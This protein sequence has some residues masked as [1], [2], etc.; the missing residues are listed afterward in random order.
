MQTLGRGALLSV[1]LMIIM[2]GLGLL[3][4]LLMFRRIHLRKCL[5]P[6]YFKSLTFLC[7]GLRLLI[8]MSH[9]DPIMWSA[10]CWERK[11]K[12][13]LRSR[14]LGYSLHKIVV[15]YRL[16]L[17]HRMYIPLGGNR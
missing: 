7:A 12:E 15:A 2:G 8:I 1:G 9:E 10:L 17:Y 5:I 16:G 3:R 13:S 11:G 6:C 4:M 14:S